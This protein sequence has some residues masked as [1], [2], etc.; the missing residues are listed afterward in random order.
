[1]LAL[2]VSAGELVVDAAQQG[3]DTDLGAGLGVNLLD[4]DGA[5]QAVLTALGWQ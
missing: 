3:V 4:D 2:R 1:M 5:V